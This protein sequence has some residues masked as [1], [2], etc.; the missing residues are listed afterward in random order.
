MKHLKKT[1][2]FIVLSCMSLTLFTAQSCDDDDEPVTS[3]T[4]RRTNIL[5]VLVIGQSNAYGRSP[6][7]MEDITYYDDFD[8]DTGGERKHVYLYN[9]TNGK[10]ERATFSAFPVLGDPEYP[11][12]RPADFKNATHFVYYKDDK[13]Y[14]PIGYSR[15]STFAKS[16]HSW[17]L[18]NV[19]P[20]LGDELVNK[21]SKYDIG[22]VCMTRGGT[23]ILQ[24]QKGYDMNSMPG[25][26]DRNTFTMDGMHYDGLNFFNESVR[27]LQAAVN[28]AHGKYKKIKIAVVFMQ[29]ESEV[30]DY[31]TDDRPLSQYPSNVGDMMH[32]IR[33][34]MSTYTSHSIPLFMSEIPQYIRCEDHT[35]ALTR[36]CSGPVNDAINR[37]QDAVPDS[38]IIPSDDLT[39]IENDEPMEMHY[40]TVSMNQLALRFAFRMGNYYD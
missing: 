17:P 4:E 20:R 18:L 9:S 8:F 2:A 30:D 15:Y 5:I 14:Y 36:Y 33:M 23:D 34:D 11:S 13:E 27:H 26:F 35:G 12:I 16:P 32:D 19:A 7:F 25:G 31:R 39:Y 10:F 1:I 6:I 24:W 28:D 22:F 40:S 3:I 21:L 37:V 38:Y 29:G